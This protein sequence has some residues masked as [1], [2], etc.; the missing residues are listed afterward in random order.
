M[1]ETSSATPW[2]QVNI[3]FPG[4]DPRARER[5]AIAHLAPLLP[6]AEAD[7]LITSW[8]F[9]RKGRWRVRYLP[10]EPS[11]RDRCALHSQLTQD[12]AWTGDIY[13][14]EVH[15]FGGHA[16]MDTAHE[17]FHADSHHLFTYLNGA[18]ADRRERSLVL[19]T[20]LMRAAG[21]EFEEQGDVWARIAEQ[22]VV[23]R[24]EPP[25]PATWTA[26]TEDVHRLLLGTARPDDIGEAWLTAFEQ[27]GE[28][29]RALRESGRL[30]RG[31]RAVTALHV[32]FHWN[33]IGI[34]GSSQAA[35][36]CAAREA[37]FAST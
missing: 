15:A 8:F 4:R 32:I 21:L 10:T 17:L 22:R 33:R 19:C 3:D 24:R 7:G 16:S 36:A 29:L 14:P 20:A 35:L 2:A 31:V 23:L 12:V 6:A 28:Q 37:I 25:D 34:T 9:I 1:D 13:E 5:R 30:T 26:F 11:D 18:A 27:A